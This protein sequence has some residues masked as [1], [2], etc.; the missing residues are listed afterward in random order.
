MSN[1]IK[2]ISIIDYFIPSNSSLTEAK[3]TKLIRIL[4][5][6][7]LLSLFIDAIYWGISFY[8][9][10]V[11][12]VSVTTFS[13]F[14]LF[15]LLWILKWGL[16][17]RITSHLFVFYFWTVVVSITFYSGGIQSYVLSWIS[18]IPIMALTLLSARAAWGWGIIGVFTVFT[19]YFIEY[20]ALVPSHLLISTNY[21][22]NASLHVG[23][24]FFILTLAYVFGRNQNELISK[25]EKQ[26]QE[27]SKQKDNY[28]TNYESIKT[29]SEMGS[30]IISTLSIETISERVYDNIN[31]LM[32]ADMLTIAIYNKEN[33]VLEFPRSIESGIV[34]LTRSSYHLKDDKNRLPVICFNTKNT[35]ITNDFFKDYPEYPQAVIGELPQSAIEIPLIQQHEAIGIL[36]VCSKKKNAYSD[37]HIYILKNLASYISIAIQN[38]RNYT[39]IEKSNTNLALL[40]K[41]GQDISS[42]ISIEN[43]IHSV[44]QNISTLMNASK[45]GIGIIDK[46]KNALIFKDYSANSDKFDTLK[47]PLE[48]TDWLA[49]HCVVNNTEII[50]GDIKTEYSQFIPSVDKPHA[51]MMLHNS[52]II[53]PLLINEEVIGCIG[54]QYKQLNAYSDYHV[55]L[56]RS[57]AIDVSIAVANASTF[58]RLEKKSSENKILYELSSNLIE[59]LEL[60]ELLDK[61]MD[62]AVKLVPNAQS[63]SIFLQNTENMVLEGKVSHGISNEQIKKIRLKEGEGISGK[64]IAEKRS[65]IENNYLENTL[66]SPEKEQILEKVKKPMKSIVVVLLKVKQK[67]IG[68]ISL[69]NYDKNNA[70]TAADLE[71]LTSLAANASA[72]IERVRMYELVE[73]VNSD[74]MMA[75]SK[76]KELDEYKEAMT[77]MI[78][79]DFKNSL[80]TVISFS[81]G[82]PTERRLKSIRQAGQFMLTMVLNILDVQK[83]ETAKIKLALGNYPINRVIEGALN[84]LSYIIEQKYIKLTYKKPENLYV[85][86]DLELIIRV[87]VNIL[88]NAVNYVA[89]NGKIE[90]TVEK[91]KNY[92]SIS[93]KDNGP[94]ISKDNLSKVFD[95]YSQ[96]DAKKSGSVRSTGI[97]LT[98]C[99]MVVE[100]HKGVIGV[101]SEEGS[102]SIFCFTIPLVEQS[103][104]P[105]I[106]NEETILEVQHLL[107]LSNKEEEYLTTY[108]K[109]LKKW[110]VYDYSEVATIIENINSKKPN[111]VLW[112]EKMVRALQNVNEEEYKELIK[113]EEYAD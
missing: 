43:I 13:F 18:L 102:G 110:E 67:I 85:R 64:A 105:I 97:G 88:S 55:N 46:S 56:L 47:F 90:I 84:Q 53:L 59:S 82:E 8:I 52:I 42:N 99:K 54:V 104:E 94:G 69:D 5:K 26:N 14:F 81:D 1:P 103:N 34:D 77:S 40:N 75:Y 28:K 51:N 66:L 73:T 61:V 32:P 95:K 106:E 48:N 6:F 41:I 100:A 83:F 29:L 57:I 20:D 2:K 70:F 35:L 12:V 63:G 27:I 37:Y 112:K 7:I 111:I 30:E 72:A 19:F 86:I 68:T 87:L 3:N 39:N 33:N 89:A 58:E 101:E 10:F 11:V 79:H 60:E 80:N 71:T 9:N 98:F 36:E 22:W 113:I 38:S 50:S 4:I 16:S 15:S 62:A 91:E 44:Y 23:L 96:L 24:Q 76:L 92:F 17:L 108:K 65:F 93:I 31:R 45:F 74:L 107:I 109:E 49:V 21:L 25:I 78:V